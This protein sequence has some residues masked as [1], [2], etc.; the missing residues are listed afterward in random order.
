ML[1]GI[2]VAGLVPLLALAASAQVLDSDGDGIPD[3]GDA[4]GSPYDNPCPNLQAFDCDDNC[5]LVANPSQAD[6]SIPADGIGDACQALTPDPAFDFPLQHDQQVDAPK[7]RW[8]QAPGPFLDR[9]SAL[10]APPFALESGATCRFIDNGQFETDTLST[11]YTLPEPRDPPFGGTICCTWEADCNFTCANEDDFAENDCP[12]GVVCPGIPDFTSCVDAVVGPGSGWDGFDLETLTP[13]ERDAVG[14]A[15]RTPGSVC[16]G[17]V[18]I[19]GVT[20]PL[21]A[22]CFRETTTAAARWGGDQSPLDDSA[23]GD[24]HPIGCD[25]CPMVYNPSQLD[26]DGDGRGDACDSAPNNRWRCANSENGGAGDI[27]AAPNDCDDCAYGFFDPYNDGIDPDGNLICTPEP[28]RAAMLAA[29][30]L[31]LGLMGRRRGE[32]R[33]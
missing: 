18:E 30:L 10:V 7:V 8:K 31:L 24:R 27:P 16:D 15:A 20:L 33:R 28:G 9:A 32:E 6:S 11:T 17:I 2:V 1:T 13:A 21:P 23:D 29:G 3:D 19:G 5:R 22:C 26:S 25:N 14:L 4:S 12:A